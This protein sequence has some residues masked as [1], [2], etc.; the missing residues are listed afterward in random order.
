MGTPV[1]VSYVKMVPRS[2]VT[3]E[4][5]AALEAVGR[6]FGHVF[7]FKTL[8]AG[9]A[10][11]AAAREHRASEI[12]APSYPELPAGPPKKSDIVAGRLKEAIKK[13]PTASAQIM[14]SW[15]TEDED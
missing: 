2:A 4:A 9:G 10:A 8:L 3:A 1:A 12:A 13:D 14:R 7:H 11:E 15:L 6:K 5:V